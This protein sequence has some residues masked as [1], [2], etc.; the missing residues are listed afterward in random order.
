MCTT[1]NTKNKNIKNLIFTSLQW[2]FGA[3][4]V[5]GKHTNRITGKVTRKAICM[6]I[7]K[8][9]KTPIITHNNYDAIESDELVAYGDYRQPWKLDS[10]AS[11]HYCGRNTGVRKRRAQRNGIQVQVADGKSMNQVEEGKAPFD[12]M[13]ADA[14]DVEIFQHM[15]N[16]LCSAGKIVKQNHKII[17]DD[18]I[19]TVINKATNEVVMEAVFDHRTSTW[20]IYPD[21][22]VP[23]EFKKEQEIESLG[24]GVQQQ[25]Q[26]Q[27]GGYV[28]HFANNAYR[29]TT[30]KEI[31]EFYHAAAGWPVKKTWIAAIQRNAYASW[32]GLTEYMV[33][34]HLEVREPTVL[35]H[36]NAR[37][38]GTQSTKK[39]NKEKD[40][41]E[42]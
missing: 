2:H 22:P 14:A 10:G 20:D 33:R 32:P 16:P 3:K 17:L 19:A 4:K 27:T 13:P 37:R 29:L 34:R 1:S 36:M 30:Q 23:Y 28:I 15:P 18:P 21:G 6:S 9:V 31:V 41:E 26:Q 42:R 38:S 25:Q 11:G 8:P 5:E 35:G 40:G 39:K 7:Q 12:G 24:L